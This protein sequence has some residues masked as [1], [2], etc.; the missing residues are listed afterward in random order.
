VKKEDGE[1]QKSQAHYMIKACVILA[2]H[3]PKRQSAGKDLL[4]YYLLTSFFSSSR[5]ADRLWLKPIHSSTSHHCAC[6]AH[7][8]A[9]SHDL[10]PKL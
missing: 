3:H 10:T 6:F 8:I 9:T 1:E 4:Y 2:M 5:S 7:F